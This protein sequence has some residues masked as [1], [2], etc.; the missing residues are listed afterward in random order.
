MHFTKKATLTTPE[1]DKF[2]VEFN[3]VRYKP[4]DDARAVGVLLFGLRP[5]GISFE[6]N[7]DPSVFLY[8][9]Q[10]V[11]AMLHSHANGDKVRLDGRRRVSLEDLRK[12]VNDAV[13]LAPDE[14]SAIRA[15]ALI[16][17]N[18]GPYAYDD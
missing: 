16:N 12:W 15:R 13:A 2:Q 7:R 17:E 14:E 10:H 3:G 1:P 8:F 18:L 6:C 9:A 4:T 5:K 11:A